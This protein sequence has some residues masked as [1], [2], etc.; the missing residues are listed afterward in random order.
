[1]LLLLFWGHKLVFSLAMRTHI[2]F[3][4]DVAKQ[5]HTHTQTN[6]FGTGGK[7]K[8]TFILILEELTKREATSISFFVRPTAITVCSMSAYFSLGHHI[9]YFL[10]NSSIDIKERN[11]YH[12]YAYK[13][14]IKILLSRKTNIFSS[15]RLLCN[16]NRFSSMISE[17]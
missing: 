9:F 16:R 2:V 5:T 17:L 4:P 10:S 14:R 1:M 6:K 15:R 3:Q 13:R 12:G 11:L 8:G 7:E